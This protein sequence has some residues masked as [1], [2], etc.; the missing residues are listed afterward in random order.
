ME[1]AWSWRPSWP[2]EPKRPPHGGLAITPY[3]AILETIVSAALDNDV[4]TF[5]A[6]GLPD[7]QARAF[8]TAHEDVREK[9]TVPALKRAVYGVDVAA[10]SIII[11]TVG[12]VVTSLRSEIAAT[13]NGLKTEVASVHS[14]L[15]ADGAGLRNE[16]K[17]EVTVCAARWSAGSK[18]PTPG[19]MPRG[20]R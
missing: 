11:V 13:R 14:E 19:S 12:L 18:P 6:A 8:A 17:T 4:T 20:P 9:S 1:R 5:T 2:P 3:T 7:Q 15:K 10:T 16:I